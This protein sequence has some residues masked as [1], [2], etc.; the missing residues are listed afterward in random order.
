M[1]IHSQIRAALETKLNSITDIPVISWENE[2]FSPTTGVAY[3]KTKYLPTRQDPAYLGPL[4]QLRYEG[5]FRVDC[6]VPFGGGPFLGDDL[7]QDVLDSFRATT[8]IY[9]NNQTDSLLTEDE[10]FIV[11]ESGQR[12]LL[13]DVIYVTFQYSDR[14]GGEKLPDGPFYRIIVNIGWYVYN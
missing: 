11:L 13:D 3:I 10:A 1:G 4:P 2:D 7:A 14:E 9:Y 6:I 5:V 12:V 8:S